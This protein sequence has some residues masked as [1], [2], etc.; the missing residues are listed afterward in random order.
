MEIWG[1]RG[2]W[3][4]TGET[5]KWL[6]GQLVWQG[7]SSVRPLPSVLVT[8]RTAGGALYVPCLTLLPKCVL[9][10]DSF[11]NPGESTLDLPEPRKGSTFN[12]LLGGKR[13]NAQKL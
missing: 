1:E 7:L 9:T 3:W 13:V 2:S 10:L 12:S 4:S 5:G 11:Q 6:P 8:R